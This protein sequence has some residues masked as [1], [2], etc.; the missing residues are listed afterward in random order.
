M[1]TDTAGSNHSILLVYAS[2]VC[3]HMDL[4]LEYFDCNQGHGMANGQVVV[5][6][7]VPSVVEVGVP[8]PRLS[9]RLVPPVA[10]ST[11]SVSIISLL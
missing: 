2:C 7:I 1:L 5:E 11:L 10:S 9:S 6:E 8:K 4:L 3:E